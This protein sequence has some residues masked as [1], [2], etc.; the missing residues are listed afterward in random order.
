M[1]TSSGLSIGPSRT[2]S[3]D[4]PS[5]HTW[6][7][8]SRHYPWSITWSWALYWTRPGKTE[9][10][11]YFFPRSWSMNGYGFICLPLGFYLSWQPTMLRDIK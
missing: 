8:A 1:R 4:G 10:K 5:N 11:N 9:W 2:F 7:L 6:V 3:N